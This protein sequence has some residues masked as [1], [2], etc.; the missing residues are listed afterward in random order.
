MPP[1]D[2]K[3]ANLS[4]AIALA[5]PSTKHR[6]I[7]KKP[8]LF[9]DSLSR[10]GGGI[11]SG[12]DS[13]LEMM[14]L[15]SDRQRAWKERQRRQGKPGI[16][17]NILGVD[18]GRIK[19]LLHPEELKRIQKLGGTG[20]SKRHADIEFRGIEQLRPDLDLEDPRSRAASQEMVDDPKLLEAM[21]TG[22]SRPKPK[23]GFFD[24]GGALA[25]IMAHKDFG[26]T[27]MDFGLGL[28][29][30]R[31]G[32][33]NSLTQAAAATQKGYKAR[34]A[35]S[36]AAAMKQAELAVKTHEAMSKRMEAIRKANPGLTYDEALKHVVKLMGGDMGFQGASDAQMKQ[37][38]EWALQLMDPSTIT[39]KTAK[40]VTAVPTL[41]K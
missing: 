26:D 23:P 18:T 39:P 36:T 9:G 20:P 35:A 25:D 40:N 38:R 3:N 33:M 16:G 30:S 1:F 21:R 12:I 5:P 2:Q 19:D 17:G 13:L 15:E 41:K 31:G 32:L 29:Q 10:I 34:K 4:H 22:T 24:K 27:M 6:G 37:A 7:Q 14:G 28:A 11:G 8:W